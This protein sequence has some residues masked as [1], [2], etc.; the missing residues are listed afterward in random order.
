M[1]NTKRCFVFF[2]FY[3]RTGIE[4]YLEEQAQKGWL[5]DKVSAAGWHFHRIEPQKLHFSVVYFA[6]ASAFDPEPSEAQLSFQDFCEHT[7]WKLASSNV[8]MQIFYNEATDPTPIETDASLD[9]AAIHA[10]AKKSHLPTFYL[11][12]FTGILQ[13]LLYIFRFVT[14]PLVLLTSNLDLFMGIYWFFFLLFS[15][16][17]IIHYHSWHKKARKAAELDGSFVTTSSHPYLKVAML[18]IIIFTFCFMLF[19][20]GNSRLGLIAIASIVIVLGLTAILVGLSELMKK[21]KFSAKLNRNITILLTLCTSFG[22]AGMLII[23]VIIISDTLFPEKT[24]VATY[25]VNGWTHEIYH[26]SL[27]LKVEDL[28]ET[29]YDNYSYEI[30]TR[31]QSFLAERIEAS[32]HPCIDALDRPWLDYTITVVK[33]P[34]AYEWCKS[35]MLNNFAGGEGYSETEGIIWEEPVAVDAAPWNAKEV[36]QLKFGD[37]YDMHFILCYET[38]IVELDWSHDEDLTDT[39]KK[40][41]GEKLGS[42]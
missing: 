5:L 19:V 30:D 42:M 2:S 35:A 36:Y 38:C 18:C 23:S 7:G 17:E 28:I 12:T 1:K 41:I 31:D 29:D 33:M 16:V 37:D 8:Q 9:V 3:D 14:D 22:F 10:S 25:E 27:P 13:M 34:W 26:D 24:P 39:H 4:T 32:Q 21:L 15:T 6:K 11:L 40:I 20:N